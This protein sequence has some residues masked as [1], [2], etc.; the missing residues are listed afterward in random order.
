M[1]IG[2]VKSHMSSVYWCMV[3]ETPLQ[4]RLCTWQ[5]DRTVSCCSYRDVE[6]LGVDGLLEG[7][8]IGMMPDGIKDRTKDRLQFF[9]GKHCRK[10]EAVVGVDICMY[11]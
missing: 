9:F 10:C 8:C 6:S 7:P 4:V 3:R 5:N 1:S 11:A 2:T